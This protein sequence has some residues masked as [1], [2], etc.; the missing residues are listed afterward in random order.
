M[1]MIAVF[2]FYSSH[3]KGFKMADCGA[4][5]QKSAFETESSAEIESKI[6]KDLVDKLVN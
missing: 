4:L 6:I 2:D 5:L 1:I 3:N